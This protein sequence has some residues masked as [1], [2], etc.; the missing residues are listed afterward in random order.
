MSLP[1]HGSPIAFAHRGGKAHFRENTL[2]AFRHAKQAGLSAFETDAWLS[3]DGEVV[4]D[5]DGVVRS[6]LGFR[7]KPIG[8]IRHRDLPLHIATFEELCEIAGPDANVQVDVK[9]N[10]E[11]EQVS[12]AIVEIWRKYWPNSMSNLWLAYESP[13][14]TKGD[15]VR[16]IR[17]LDADIRVI[18]STKV[19]RL[20]LSATAYAAQA[21][22]AGVDVINMRALWWNRELV[23]VV[24]DAGLLA[25]A[26]G[27]QRTERILELIDLGIDGVYSDHVDRLLN[28]LER[29]KTR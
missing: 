4:L 23:R 11:G 20:R 22:A 6:F 15:H 17:D 5:H 25:F 19:W 29:A 8:E 10:D 7:K 27:A 26:F 24:H 14:A 2:D 28:A 13:K 16:R 12:A 9:G 3:K 21:R 1:H 18:D